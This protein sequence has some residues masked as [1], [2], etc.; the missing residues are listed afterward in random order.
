MLAIIFAVYI[1]IAFACWYGYRYYEEP[2]PAMS[3]VFKAL[4]FVAIGMA[5]GLLLQLLGVFY[6]A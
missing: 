1:I 6:V 4:T 3:V 2:D 5:L